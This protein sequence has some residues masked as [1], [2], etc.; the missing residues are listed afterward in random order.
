MLNP[1][2]RGERVYIMDNTS[3]RVFR[4]ALIVEIHEDA[5]TCYVQMLDCNEERLCLLNQIKKRE[6]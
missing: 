3:Q 4:D 1:F 6:V 5:P 2:K